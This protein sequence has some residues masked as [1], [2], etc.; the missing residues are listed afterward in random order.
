MTNLAEIQAQIQK[1]QKQESDMR[2]KDFQKTVREIKEKMQAFGITVKDLQSPK[3]AKGAK[4]KDAPKVRVAGGK[5]A[6]GS[7]VAAKYRGPEGQA[8]SGRGLTPRWMTSLVEQGRTKDE[9][10]IQP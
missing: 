10:L 3:V 4:I 2:S 6:S 5:K 8:W 9:F 7:T 1:L